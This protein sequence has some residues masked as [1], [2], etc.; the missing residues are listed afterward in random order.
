MRK[1]S[2]RERYDCEYCSPFSL[3]VECAKKSSS[4]IKSDTV[5][6]IN[7]ILYIMYYCIPILYFLE[8]I[9]NLADYF[10]SRG[11]VQH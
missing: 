2:Q 4:V 1:V 11:V 5:G 7:T 6:S 9:L 8:V 10:F 3:E